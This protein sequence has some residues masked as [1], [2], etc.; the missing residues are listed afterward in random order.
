MVIL[1]VSPTM[2]KKLENSEQ[3]RFQMALD[4]VKMLIEQKVILIA[5]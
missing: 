2:N 3:T 1:D 4:S 5:F